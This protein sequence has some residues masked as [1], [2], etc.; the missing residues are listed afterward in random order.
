M[1]MA[2]VIE[3]GERLDIHFSRVV[4]A[5]SR[6]TPSLQ[7]I[8]AQT[9]HASVAGHI[10]AAKEAARR[11]QDAQ[12]RKLRDIEVAE[13]EALTAVTEV[14]DKMEGVEQALR[15]TKAR[16]DVDTTTAE[17][18]VERC[19]KMQLAA[20]EVAAKMAREA[21][22]ATENYEEGKAAVDDLQGGGCY[23]SDIYRK[24]NSYGLFT[25]IGILAA[26]GLPQRH[27]RRKPNVSLVVHPFGRA[28]YKWSGVLHD[29]HPLPYVDC[30]RNILG[31]GLHGIV[32][33]GIFHDVD[34]TTIPVVVKMPRLTRKVAQL[35]EAAAAMEHEFQVYNALRHMQGSVI[36][37]LY[38]CGYVDDWYSGR[39]IP[40]LVL[41]N[42]GG[43]NLTSLDISTLT[44]DVKIAIN[45]VLSTFHKEGWLHGD[46]AERNILYSTGTDGRKQFR[47][48][49]LSLAER[50]ECELDKRDEIFELFKILHPCEEDED[51]DNDPIWKEYR[52]YVN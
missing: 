46:I 39:S 42:A 29:K 30:G 34:G 40:A 41:E 12:E 28:S 14:E 48:C 6:F 47:L 26:R 36:P 2:K 5:G 16:G 11:R 15:R 37:R 4:A 9:L 3:N 17:K 38:G 33:D 21:K 1:V 24:L 19:E 23:V 44:Q 51:D 20:S 45:N 43:N 49:D 27:A 25:S 22:I 7:Q 18:E 32:C 8:T 10:K 35:N 31:G 52:S 13:E 50:W